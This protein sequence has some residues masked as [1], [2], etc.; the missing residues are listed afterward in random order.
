[1]RDIG[2]PDFPSQLFAEA[3][4]RL[5]EPTALVNDAGITGRIGR[6]A[7]LP[8]PVLA[9]TFTVNVTGAM[10]LCQ[11]VIRLWEQTSKPG[12]IVNISSI[13]S[14]LGAPSE[15][16]RYAA[17][18]AAI[19]AFTVGLWKE[20]GGSGIRVNAVAP[21]TTLT[22]IQA[23]GGDPDRP[24]RVASRI[25]LGRPAE[26]DEIAAAVLRLLSNQA[27]YITGSVRVG[28]GL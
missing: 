27:S 14:T 12:R 22:D 26:A 13:A 5:G 25:P 8:S 6:F 28:R 17:S 19:E 18:K 2:N 1:M 10:L 9:R 20:L 15:Y 3:V 24:H 21:G 23:E 7:D 4:D 11:C 16:V